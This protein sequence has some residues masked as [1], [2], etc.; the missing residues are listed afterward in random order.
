MSR[1]YRTLSVC[2]DDFGLTP[3]ISR[4]ICALAKLGRLTAVSC[5]TGAEHW[6]ASAPMLA[7]LPH[8]VDRG[9]HFNLTDGEPLSRE[10]R[11]RWPRLASLP[12]LIAMAHLA[13]LP[14]RAI[15]CAWQAQWQHF[16][17]ATGAAP[18]FVVATSTCI[19]CQACA[20]SF[21]KRRVRTQGLRC[22]TPVM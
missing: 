21:S 15:E 6:Q 14:L 5:M 9:L 22:A 16:V 18:G 3:A 4:G 12:S 10:L 20:T 11:S 17:D 2:A 7:D 19:I 13:R 1:T 8:T